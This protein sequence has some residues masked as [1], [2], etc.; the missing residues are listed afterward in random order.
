[1]IT[2]LDPPEN[3]ILT[4]E[5]AKTFMEMR[6][7]PGERKKKPVR[8]KYFQSLL[9]DGLFGSP[10]WSKAL[11]GND[12]DPFRADGQHTSTVLSSC[13]DELFPKDQHVTIFTFHL[14][15]MTERGQLF[16][17]F[18]HPKAARSNDDKLQMYA[19]SYDDL[20]NLDLP[21]LGKAL[22]GVNY[23][24]ATL[25]SV[26]ELILPASRDVGTLLADPTNRNFCLWLAQWQKAKHNDFLGKIG[27]TAEI[28]SDWL[29]QADLATK[30]WGEVLTESNPDANDYT[31][32]L[33][34]TL[35]DWC[36][37]KPL[38]PPEELRK[39]AKS[40]WERWRRMKAPTLDAIT[41]AAA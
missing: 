15:L 35:N 37:K 16:E 33:A 34:T 24:N 6:R 7:M 32:D 25:K 38:K 2:R 3:P 13:P 11:V 28:Y 9:K 20:L 39:K 30:F 14:D 36:L 5:V 17:R 4:R 31:R 23:H 8:L 27:I 21:I 19:A 29:S 26:N 18:D 1:M 10:V 40:I 22:R 12:P 41:P